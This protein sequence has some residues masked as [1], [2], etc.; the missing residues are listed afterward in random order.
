[1]ENYEN[2]T[3]EERDQA[4]EHAIEV[5]FDTSSDSSDSSSD[6]SADESESDEEAIDNLV[7]QIRGEII[8]KPRVQ[9]YIETVVDRYEDLDFKSHFRVT[10]TTFNHLLNVLSAKI[11]RDTPPT[12]GHPFTHPRKQ[13]LFALWIL[14]NPESYR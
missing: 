1:M 7:M 4:M 12:G 3:E 2:M 6:D 9:L 10:R 5:I 11:A 8:K 13:I 14:G